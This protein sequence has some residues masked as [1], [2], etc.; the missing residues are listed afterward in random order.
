M[1][2]WKFLDY[3]ADDQVPRNLIQAWYGRQDLHVQVAF[4]ATVKILAATEDWR[5]AKEFGLLK[6]RH[7][8]LGE[9]R[10]AVKE[11]KHGREHI[12]RFRPVGI[13]REEER[14]FVFLV[15][16]EKLRGGVLI[17]PDT[18]DL[19]LAL[20]AKLEAGKGDTREHY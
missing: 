1:A 11:K 3:L 14:E 13:W 8:G 6:K 18:F 7:I 19:A 12:R 17:P 10:F 16:C 2:L 4:D 20:K 9:L 5:R 15:G